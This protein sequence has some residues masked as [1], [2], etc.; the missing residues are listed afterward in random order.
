MAL[1]PAFS[2]LQLLQ[3]ATTLRL[4]QGWSNGTDYT[5]ETCEYK[6]WDGCAPVLPGLPGHMA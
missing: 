2:G 4:L 1:F 6:V 5:Q 3:V